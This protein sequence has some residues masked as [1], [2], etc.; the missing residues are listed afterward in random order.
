M[1]T[2]WGVFAAAFLSATLLM[3][4]SEAALI[5]AA[6]YGTSDRL[7]LFAAA[8]TGNVLGAVVNYALGAWALRFEGRRWFPVSSRSRQKAERVFAR[9]GYPVL[10]LSWLP[11]IGDPLTVAAGMLRMPFALFLVLVAI[12]KAARYAVLLWLIS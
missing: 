9:F 4:V 2:L 8:T 7:A 6:R 12:G 3:G 11:I 10:L 5:A 1:S